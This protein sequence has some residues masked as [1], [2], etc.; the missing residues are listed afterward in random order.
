MTTSLLLAVLAMAAVVITWGGLFGL[1][2]EDRLVRARGWAIAAMALA[3]A[4]A[5]CGEWHNTPGGRLASAFLILF[6]GGLILH[7]RKTTEKTVDDSADLVID[8]P[9]S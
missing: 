8:R 6:G 3:I 5:A 9:R 1:I 7:A 2:A 4:F